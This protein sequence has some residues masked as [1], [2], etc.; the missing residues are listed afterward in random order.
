MLR[1]GF[2]SAILPAWRARFL[3]FLDNIDVYVFLFGASLLPGN[4]DYPLI[5]AAGK[6]LICIFVG[7]DIRHWSAS[8]PARIIGGLEPFTGYRSGRTLDEALMTLRMAERYADALL[9]LPSYGELAARPYHH[10]N[11]GLRLDRYHFNVPQRDD[12]LVVHAPSHRAYKGTAEIV[13]QLERLQRSGFKFE[14]RLLE[15]TSH[16]EVRRQLAEA[17]IVLDQIND[18]HHG[19]LALEGMASGCAVASGNSPQIVPIPKDRPILSVSALTLR[20]QMVRLLTDKS[21]RL[22]LAHEGR[23]FVEKHHQHVHL[24]GTV[25]ELTSSSAPRKPD[26]FPTYF[27]RH[28]RLPPD[29]QLSNRVK[30]LTRHIVG[31]HGLPIDISAHSLIQR[32]LMSR[33]EDGAIPHWDVSP[34]GLFS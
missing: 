20:E 28:Y 6:K 15:N 8:E 1:K 24:A 32:G 23:A 17:D 10:L 7:S 16:D 25:L 5:K 29:V 9:Y 19:M 12:P 3:P 27:A 2:S 34:N 11:L 21:L 33:G 13:G 18:A 30:R 4:L 26:Y 14:F 31:R 22:A